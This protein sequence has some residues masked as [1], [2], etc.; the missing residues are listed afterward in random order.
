MFVELLATSLKGG[1]L[2]VTGNVSAQVGRDGYGKFD[3]YF[4]FRFTKP[5]FQGLEFSREFP[6]AEQAINYARDF[7][8][9]I[10]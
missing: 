3:S 9:A 1:N 7:A 4:T 6:S 10:A 8:K 5:N 2:S